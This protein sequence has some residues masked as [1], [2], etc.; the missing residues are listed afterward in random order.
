VSRFILRRLLLMVPVIIVTSIIAFSLILLLP[1]DPA[2][3]M[4]GDMN[5]TNTDAYRAL[6]AELGLDQP[7]PLQYLGWVGKAL[8]GNFGYSLRD[9]LPV[10]QEL[11]NHAMPT[12]E[13]AVLALVLAVVVAVIAGS[14]SALRPNSLADIVATLVAFSGVAV[15]HFFLGILLIYAF[16]LG[17]RVLPPS[18]YV[19]PWDNLGQNLRL[20]ALPS[21]TL[22]AGLA[23]VLTRQIRSALIEV[24]QQ[25]YITAARAK[26]LRERA[27]VMRHAFKNALVPISTVIGL[28]VGT[29]I[30]GAVITETIFSIPG[31]GRMIVDSIFF[32]DFPTVQA[33]VLILALLVL[34]TNLVTDLVYAA[35]DP[36][37]RFS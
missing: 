17:L 6:R 27:V 20:M 10:G 30:G 1:G 7:V 23:A 26:G 32:R 25:E 31:M 37:I 22:G 33:A 28:Q 3:M 24:M 36:R 13:L 16:S 2:L 11:A 5:A 21:L 15:P 4:L 19:A 34:V 18:G 14:V 9:Q 35:V 29:L 8:R 12:L